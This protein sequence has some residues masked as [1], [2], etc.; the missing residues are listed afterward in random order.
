VTG[1]AVSGMA[2]ICAPACSE[3][4]SKEGVECVEPIGVLDD[5]IGGEFD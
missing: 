3:R 5:D 1:S 4:L 2:S